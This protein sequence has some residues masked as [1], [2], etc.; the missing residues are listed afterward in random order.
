M[1]KQIRRLGYALL[2]LFVLLLATV[3]YVQ[4]VA[5]ARIA[6]NP[7][8]AF[9]QLVAE[10]RVQRGRILARDLTTVLAF[11]KKG[12]GELKYGRHYPDGRRYSGITGYYSLLF[13]RGE[14][15]QSQNQFL[16][17]NA[18]ELLPQTLVDKI[19]SRPVQGATV[20]TTI[21]PAIQKAACRAIASL[22][23]GGAVVAIE[24]ATGDVLA[25]CSNP[26]YDP[27][28]ISSQDVPQIRRAWRRLN[29]DPGQPLVPRA[30]AQLFP[31][32]STFKLVT[33]AAALENGYG[34]DSLWPNPASLTL[35]LTSHRLHNFGGEI[36]SGGSHIT[37]ADAL[38]Q[39]CNVVFGG[40]GLKLGPD[41]MAEEARKFGF[42]ADTASGDVP[43]DVPFREGVFPTP[44]AFVGQPASVAFSAI[45]QFDVSA[46]P[47]QMALVASAIAN[48]GV[49]LAPRLVT[50]IRDSQ[51][52]IVKTFEPAEYSRP[53]TAEHA[54]QLRDM[55]VAVVQSGTG[56]AAQIPGVTVA[57]KTG[58]AQH[59]GANEPPHA[60][61]T[62]FAPAENPQVAV[63]VI[64][65]DGG[66]LGSDATGGRVAAPIAKQVIEAALGIS[67]GA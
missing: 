11:S 51:G 47:M 37:L 10:Y 3:S 36:C 2:A 58:T 45:G 14:L 15:E 66:D 49:L 63:A 41:R 27:S 25:M 9:R 55:M 48:D 5:A 24:P 54:H 61:F 19:L 65:L 8:N 29:A 30:D 42:A 52:Q 46:N 64:V 34:P 62:A 6:D 32:G 60:W 40:I 43:F 28:D 4:V 50:Q 21:D 33:A 20:V 57:G 31:P 22:P 38:R 1:D 17:G 26:A 23:H 12:A 16:S 59:G 18:A 7:A 39:S 56:Y 44:S 13:G 53:L 35:P 67:G